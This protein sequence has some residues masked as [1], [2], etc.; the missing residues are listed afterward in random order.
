MV[1]CYGKSIKNR[2]GPVQDKSP[3]VPLAFTCLHFNILFQFANVP[4]LEVHLDGRT[5]AA[6]CR[7]KGAFKK[8][9]KKDASPIV[10]RVTDSSE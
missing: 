9:P 5:Q 10:S 3:K 8:A 4:R 6:S 7:L 1:S 2:L